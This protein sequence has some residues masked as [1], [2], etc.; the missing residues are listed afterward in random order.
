MAGRPTNVLPA[1]KVEATVLQALQ[2]ENIPR[3]FESRVVID[4]H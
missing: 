4:T 3:P 2:V 1:G